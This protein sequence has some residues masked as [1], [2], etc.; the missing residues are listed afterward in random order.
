MDS[1][2]VGRFLGARPNT[3]IFRTFVT[4]K[5]ALKGQVDINEMATRFLS[6]SFSFE[7]D[8]HEILCNDPLVVGKHTLVL[9]KWAPNLYSLY[10]SRIQDLVWIRLIG[11][12]LDFWVE[13]VFQGIVVLLVNSSLW[14]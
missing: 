11:L 5:W 12:L 8:K 6:F 2:L 3:K 7:E 10:E 1:T 13:E 9:Q 4:K 14:I